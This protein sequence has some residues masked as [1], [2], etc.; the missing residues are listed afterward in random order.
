L[1]HFDKHTKKRVVGSHQLLVIDSHE[2]H[3]LLAFQH[4]CK[5]NKI[6][7]ICMPPYSLHLLQP[8]DVGCFATLKKAY[9]RQAKDL[10]R[11]RITPVTKL[12]FLPCF[13][14][15]YNAAITPRN[16]QGGFQGA[17]LVSYDS[18]Q[19]ITALYMQLRTPSLLLPI[20]NKPCQLQ[21]QEIPL[22]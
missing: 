21:T 1:K 18:E 17:G 5:E 7:T 2:S 15:A 14:R 12:E 4:Y 8:L 16:I 6:I 10:M 13:I 19:V 3:D 20:N 9:E 22:N 11:N